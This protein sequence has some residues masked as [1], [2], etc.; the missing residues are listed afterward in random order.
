[1]NPGAKEPEPKRG[2]N[3]GAQTLGSFGASAKG[4]RCK[5]ETASGSTRSNGYA[6]NPN[7][8]PK[9][10]NTKKGAI[11]SNRAFL[12]YRYLPTTQRLR[13]QPEQPGR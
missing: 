10:P 5:S 13:R 2:P 7:P 12:K 4:T 8:N 6:P 9:T 3:A 1:M 11:L